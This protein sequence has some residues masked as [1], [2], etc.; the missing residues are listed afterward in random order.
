MLRTI[1]R[2]AKRLVPPAVWQRLRALAAAVPGLGLTGSADPRT[3]TNNVYEALYD[4]HA[5][6]HGDEVIGDGSFEL[7]GRLEL[8]VLLAEGLQPAHRVID[9]GC[10]TGRLA[11]H[12]IPALTGGEYV[13]IEVSTTI[14]ERARER[15]RVAIPTPPCRVQWVH[16][17]SPRFPFDDGSVDMLAAFSVFTHMEHE[18]TYRYLLDARRIVK[19]GGR[20]I[21]SCLPMSLDIA[22]KIFL[23][24]AEADFQ[25]RWNSVRNV[26]TSEPLMETIARLAAWTPVRWYRGDEP[27]ITLVDTDDVWPF[28]QSICVLQPS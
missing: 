23:N 22:H 6:L 21:F 10:G 27:N 18:D 3:W 28:G 14:L 9:L 2:N 7:I 20:F 12:L 13:G 16:Q 5:R 17:T 8:S 19:P 11:L 4:A 15:I 24:S 26:T 25:H 1:K